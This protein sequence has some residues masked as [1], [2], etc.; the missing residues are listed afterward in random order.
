MKKLYK[1]LAAGFCFAL[2]ITAMAQQESLMKL[3]IETLPEIDGADNIAN[4]TYSCNLG[5]IVFT[6]KSNIP[7][8]VFESSAIDFNPIPY[9]TVKHIYVFCHKKASFWLKI[10]S[11]RHIVEKI[12]IDPSRP[13]HVFKITENMPVGYVMFDVKPRNAMVDFGLEGQSASPSGIV[14]KQNAGTYKVKISKIGFI[15]IDTTVLV[16]S[17]GSTKYVQLSLEEDFA[18]ISFDISAADNTSFLTLPTVEIDKKNI[19]MADLYDP[20]KKRS[21]DDAAP[22]ETFKLYS[23]G[24]VPVP[25]GSHDITI[26]VSGYKTYQTSIVTVRGSL[27][28]VVVK[29]EPITGFLSIVDG[30]NADGAKVF[31]NDVPI[32]YIPIFKHKTTIGMHS[33]KVEKT[34][35]KAEQEI[36]RTLVENEIVSEIK[37][38]MTVFKHVSV[39]T[40][41]AGAEVVV[42]GLRMGFS[43]CD[44]IL[45]PGK[46]ALAVSKIGFLPYKE[47]IVVYE[48][49]ENPYREINLKLEKCFPAMLTSERENLRVVVSRGD[50]VVSEGLTTPAKLML[51]YGTYRVKLL[52]DN[53]MKCFKGKVKITQVR[54]SVKLPCYSYGTFSILVADFYLNMPTMKA[55]GYDHLGNIHFGRF[56]LFPGFSTSIVRFSAFSL[57]NKK[58][59]VTFNKDGTEYAYERKTMT[60][61]LSPAGFNCEFRTG[62]AILRNLDI[63]AVGAFAYYPSWEKKVLKNFDLDYLTGAEIFAGV[64]FATRFSFANLNIK[65]GYEFWKAGE[66]KYY[67]ED[68]KE[69]KSE[70]FEL[71]SFCFSMGF[72]FGLVNH[73]ANNMLRLWKKPWVAKY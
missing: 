29:L 31:L 51:P 55:G 46:N 18:K 28:P 58:E 49:G 30:G 34:G 10:S 9:D 2:S 21:F 50:T 70:K 14:I 6:I 67:V 73:K 72:S 71:G 1:I 66:L 60:G 53:G 40:E 65:I 37:V 33:I 62:G 12:Y 32:G 45:L 38:T 16:S 26:S 54:D 19:N 7:D 13:K 23:D 57:K 3:N 20:T 48:A 52:N 64:E 61:N 44:L 17:D 36:Y 35:F 11:P 41:P 68:L 69:Y 15:S 4:E 56:N 5:D 8:L 63:S 43:P 24:I 25:S 59:S 39:A 47:T 42:N 22:L 27:S